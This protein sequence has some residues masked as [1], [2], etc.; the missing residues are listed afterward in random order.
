MIKK[1]KNINL[2]LIRVISMIFVVLIYILELLITDTSPIKIIV[3]SILYTCNGMFFMLSG[4]LNLDK[5]IKTK[6]RL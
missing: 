5:R 6:K 3:R 2:D 4:Y 1:N